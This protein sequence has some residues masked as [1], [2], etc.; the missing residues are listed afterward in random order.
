MKGTVVAVWMKTSKKNFGEEL[1]NCSMQE[2]GWDKDRIFSPT[3]D[4]NDSEIKTYITSLAGKLGKNEYEVWR[5]IGKY[6]MEAFSDSYPAFFEHENL[7]SFLKSMFDVHVAITKRI[8]GAQP[9][10][11]T[12]KPVSKREA[13]FSYKSKRGMFGYLEGMLEGA[14]KHFNEN[15]KTEILTKTDDSMEVKINFENDIHYKKVYKLN[16]ILG[17][18][19]IKNVEAKIAIFSAVFLGVLGVPLSYAINNHLVYSVVTIGIGF[20]ASFMGAKL[21]FLP[22]NQIA[23]ELDELIEKKFSVDSKIETGDEFENLYN[24]INSN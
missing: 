19:F 18:G 13:V 20:L 7:Y 5:L 3:E 2:A 12:L 15:I 10:I 8:K 17:L 23:R 9:P 6:N 14:A 22:Q 24:K 16:K 11:V 4:I 21:L 1:T